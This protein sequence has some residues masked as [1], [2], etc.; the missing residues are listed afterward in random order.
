MVR[1]RGGRA[2][3]L[4]ALRRG[5]ERSATMATAPATATGC[6]SRRPRSARSAGPA[7]DRYTL[8]NGSM[9]VKILSYGGI[10]QELWAPDR[11]GRQA[12]VTLGYPDLD[13]YTV[14]RGDPPGPN[15]RTSAA[16][17]AAT[18]TASRRRRS[19]STATTYTLDVNNGPNSLHGGVQ[20]FDRFVWDAESFER[21]G[22][23]GVKLTRTSKDGE[24]CVPDAD[25]PPCTTGYPGQPRRRGRL[26]ARQ[27]QQPADRLRGD[28]RRADGRQPHQPRLLEP[29][30]ARARGRSTTTGSRSTRTSTRRSTR[31]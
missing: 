10:I 4:R 25:Q 26:H 24:G 19:R 5:C 12:N 13:G 22:V 28:D 18:A 16:S 31:R 1:D 15:P 3:G 17:S 7:V 30:R 6:R 29:R 27:A 2:G 14:P 9:T 8:S 21:P 11:R 23:V 20:G